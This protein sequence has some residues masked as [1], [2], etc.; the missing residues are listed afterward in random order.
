[1]VDTY[2]CEFGVPKKTT[3]VRPFLW[4][5]YTATDKRGLF[6]CP[7]IEFSQ[8]KNGVEAGK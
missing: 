6:P 8:S 2:V 3:W 7:L 5:Y 1:M 4:G